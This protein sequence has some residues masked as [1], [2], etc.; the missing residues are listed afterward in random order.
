MR[1]SIRDILIQ[2]LP[3]KFDYDRFD[4]AKKVIA[5]LETEIELY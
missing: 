1:E 2:G 5:V 4:F 3:D